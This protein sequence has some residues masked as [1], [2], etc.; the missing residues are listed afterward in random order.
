MLKF[1]SY[2]SFKVGYSRSRRNVKKEACASS[3]AVS[4]W[5]HGKVKSL[6]KFENSSE[7]ENISDRS[8]FYKCIATLNNIRSCDVNSQSLYTEDEKLKTVPF[9]LQCFAL[10]HIKDR[11]NLSQNPVLLEGFKN[12]VN[13]IG[14]V[15]PIYCRNPRLVVVLLALA[16]Q[17]SFQMGK[18]RSIALRKRPAADLPVRV[19]T[20]PSRRSERMTKKQTSAL[21]TDKQ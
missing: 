16:A 18:S 8:E 14:L 5:F 3:S 12:L 15:L 10:L 11:E 1:R 7:F 2:C 20:M 19:I 4:G 9:W 21:L 17:H 13:E 6:E